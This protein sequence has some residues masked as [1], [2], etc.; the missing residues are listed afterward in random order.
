MGEPEDA[1]PAGS[2]DD[3]GATGEPEVFAAHGVSFEIPAGW[4]VD[5]LR[6][7]GTNRWSV[8]WAVVAH[9]P[10]HYQEEVRMIVWS[11][12]G[13]LAADVAMTRLDIYSQKLGTVEGLTPTSVGGLPA[14][15]GK[16]VGYARLGRDLERRVVVVVRGTAAYEISCEYEPR[17]AEAIARCDQVV[18][19]LEFSA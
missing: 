5:E 1:P 3:D 4:T 13:M 2:I 12:G 8:A 9:Q 11:T 17:S 18:D 19:T 7:P 16:V 6:I 14:F 10:L 15:E